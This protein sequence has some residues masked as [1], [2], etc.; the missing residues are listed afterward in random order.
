[1]VV[2]IERPD[3]TENA[4]G[5][6]GNFKTNRGQILRAGVNPGGKSISYIDEDNMVSS[7]NLNMIMESSSK[8]I[9]LEVAS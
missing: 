6:L 5:N 8:D 9:N 3:G 4:G 1:M 2:N 7:S